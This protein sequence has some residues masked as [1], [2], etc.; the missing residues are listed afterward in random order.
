VSIIKVNIENY[1]YS[2]WHISKSMDQLYDWEAYFNQ[3]MIMLN[4]LKDRVMNAQ[5]YMKQLEKVKLI[6]YEQKIETEN[7]KWDSIIPVICDF[8]EIDIDDV[9]TF[10]SPYSSIFKISVE[11]LK[12]KLQKLIDWIK[13]P[14]LLKELISTSEL[15]YKSTTTGIW[16]F[17][18]NIDIYSQF[19]KLKKYLQVEYIDLIELAK[20]DFVYFYSIFDETQWLQKRVSHLASIIDLSTEEF[21][22]GLLHRHPYLIHIKPKKLEFN[23]EWMSKYFNCKKSE[24]I[25]LMHKHPPIMY[26]YVSDLGNI[27]RKCGYSFS[28]HYDNINT[29]KE[30]VKIFFE[31]GYY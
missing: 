4:H 30:V 24:L 7:I 11:E 9:R 29:L 15:S 6:E 13:D 21:I 23:L 20:I 19:D 28:T 8:F 25:S 2:P 5:G 22:I 27:F 12:I 14:S 31:K 18:K 1:K 26:W 10:I 16:K 3:R 17:N